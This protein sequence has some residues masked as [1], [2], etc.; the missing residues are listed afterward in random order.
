[1]YHSFCKFG[2]LN[3]DIGYTDRRKV[4]QNNVAEA[5]TK[6]EVLFRWICNY[7]YLWTT[8]LK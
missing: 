3:E 6:G 4:Q 8:T 7:E 2:L 1:M 5:S